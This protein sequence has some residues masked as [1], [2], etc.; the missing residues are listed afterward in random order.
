MRRVVIALL[1]LAVV[2]ACWAQDLQARVETMA[3][4]HQGKIAF[5]A[6]DL[7]TGATVGLDPD[8]PVATASVIKVAIMVEAFYEIKAGK[9]RLDE[10][11]T[12]TKQ[13]QVEGSGVLTLMQPGLQPTLQDAITL[14]ITQS[15]NTAT[16]MVIDAIGIPAVNQRIAAM[17]LKNTYLYKKVFMPP[18]GPTPAD[19]KQFGLGKT[20]PHEMAMILESIERCDLGDK[21]LCEQ[22]IGMMKNQF[23]RNLI[24]RYLETVDTTDTTSAIANKTGSEDDVRNDVGIV[25]TKHGPIVISAFTYANKDQS[26]TADNEAEVFVGKLAKAVVDAWT[27]PT[28]ASGKN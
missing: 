27:A 17:G 13:N 22:M 25:Y 26:W 10:R 2:T 3:T 23:Y 7:K 4:E 11:L 1:M 15:D 5:F 28:T 18:V 14:M 24:P 12:L 20:T 16:N 19:Q 8:R 6:K 9:H 21:K